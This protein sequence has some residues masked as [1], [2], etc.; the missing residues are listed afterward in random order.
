MLIA[1]YPAS[2]DSLQHLL[3]EH[4]A[5]E[6]KE[7]PRQMGLDLTGKMCA[8]EQASDPF[9]SELQWGWVKFAFSKIL[10]NSE[11]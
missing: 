7:D 6:G 10:T 4:R 2:N 1:A 11:D 8:S 5:S 9:Q 3:E